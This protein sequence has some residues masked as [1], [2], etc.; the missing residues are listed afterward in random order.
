MKQEFN[1]DKI[2]VIVSKA[3]EKDRLEYIQNYFDKNPGFDV[4]YIDALWKTEV[5]DFS[6]YDLSMPKGHI[7]LIENNKRLYKHILENTNYERVYICESDIIFVD[8]F[9]NKFKTIINEWVNLSYEQYEISM[10]FTGNGCNFKPNAN[11]QVSPNLYKEN[12]S[13]CAESVLYTRKAVEKNY[14][15]LNNM[16]I[17]NVGFD[18]IPFYGDDKV[19]AYWAEPHIM[20]Q[21]TQNGTYTSTTLN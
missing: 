10:I 3:H 4:E 9:P 13:K 11:T 16:S 7:M 6:K 18:H 1:I 20:I 17:I 5:I 8:D 19:I 12:R 14:E 15:F 2:Y 21:G